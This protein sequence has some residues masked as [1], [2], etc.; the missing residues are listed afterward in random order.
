[1]DKST[2]ELSIPIE[3]LLKKGAHVVLAKRRVFADAK[4]RVP[5][6]S[7]SQGEIARMW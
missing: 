4:S 2:K 3:A 5:A 6:G 1:M 7:I